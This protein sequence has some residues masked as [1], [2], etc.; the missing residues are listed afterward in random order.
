MQK[1]NEP[2]FPSDFQLKVKTSESV[3]PA[4]AT[5]DINIFNNKEVENLHAGPQSVVD[6]ERVNAGI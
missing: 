5:N 3:N 2:V 4:N 1:P 6:G